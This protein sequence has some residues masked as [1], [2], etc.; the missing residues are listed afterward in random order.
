MYF[1]VGH[2]LPQEIQ[3]ENFFGI[4]FDN[5]MDHVRW[6]EAIGQKVIDLNPSG[7]SLGRS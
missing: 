7:M 3:D 6:E 5:N 1:Y 2:I 4:I